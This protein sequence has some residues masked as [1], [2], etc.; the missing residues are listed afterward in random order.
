MPVI[1]ALLTHAGGRPSVEALEGRLLASQTL[2]AD[3][4]EHVVEVVDVLNSYGVVLDAY[5]KNLIFQAERQFL[6]PFPVF[7]FL[8]GDLSPAK[9]WR[10]L[11]GDRINFEYAE[12]CMKAML[13]HGTGGLDAYLDSEPFAGNCAAIIRHKTGRDPLLAL[14]HPLF[15]NFLPEAIRAAA[16]TH[17]LGQFW[18]V[19]SDLFLDLARAEAAGTVSNIAE[20]V[21]FIKAGL[22]N[23]AANPITYGVH[24]GG[25]R[26]WVLPPEAG[27][28]FLV[29]VAVPYVEAVFLRGMPF[30]GTVSF[31]AQAQQISPDQAQFAYGALYADPLPTMGAGIPPSLLMQDMYRHLPERL[32]ALYRQRS[33]GEGDVRVKICMSFQKSMFC[34]TNAAIDGTF[35]HS[36]GTAVPAEQA[37]NR[38]YARAWAERLAVAR[39]DCLDPFGS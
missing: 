21:A 33:R 14:L 35:P 37:A 36:L 5:S 28:T 8:D 34:V 32:H 19:M 6:N 15:P 9:I 13:W 2:L 4:P 12:Y 7:R 27:L 39:T 30:L 22:V 11:N 1:P 10:H 3:T 38:A 23:A 16:T 25:E 17:A 20:V 18:R 26:F 31:N 24:L 29:D